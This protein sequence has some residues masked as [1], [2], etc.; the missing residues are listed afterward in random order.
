[1]KFSVLLAL[2]LAFTMPAYAG[3]N[4]T[5]RHHKAKLTPEQIFVKRDTDHDGFLSKAEFMANRKHP[6]KA[7]KAFA[8]RDTNGDGKLSLAEF[9]AKGKH[10]KGHKKNQ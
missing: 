1:M 8:K 7:E 2:A 10:H 5:G 6:E 9:L 3:R 4:G